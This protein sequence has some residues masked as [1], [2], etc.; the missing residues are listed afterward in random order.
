MGGR[1]QSCHVGE[2]RKT[3]ETEPLKDNDKH[4]LVM[5]WQRYLHLQSPGEFILKVWLHPDS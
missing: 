1:S 3:H 5:A 2:L 4:M